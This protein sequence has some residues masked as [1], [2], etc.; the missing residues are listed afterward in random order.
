[1]EC[2]VIAYHCSA[3]VLCTRPR[4]R[5]PLRVNSLEM[6]IR[7]CKCFVFLMASRHLTMFLRLVLCVFSFLSLF[8][9]LAMRNADVRFF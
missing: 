3:V 4:G 7:P 6:A 5:R 2:A 9:V 1:M 8:S